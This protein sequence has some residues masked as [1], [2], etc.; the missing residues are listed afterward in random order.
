MAALRDFIPGWYV[1]YLSAD[2]AR[3]QPEAGPQERMTRTGDNLANDAG[4]PAGVGSRDGAHSKRT[5]RPDLVW[6]KPWRTVS[7]EALADAHMP[8]L[9]VVIEGL[10]APRRFLDLVRDLIAFE[11]DGGRV[12]K[13]MAGYH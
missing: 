7:G 2:S 5:R 12:V 10:L 11:D 13:K 8:E 9:Q 3:G 6:F 4:D 1:S